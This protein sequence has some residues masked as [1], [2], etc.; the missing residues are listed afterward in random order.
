MQHTP[1]MVRG[2]PNFRQHYTF[3]NPVSR[4]VEPKQ[5]HCDRADESAVC[6]AVCKN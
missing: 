2:K 3:I 5:M 6:G 4:T 1:W